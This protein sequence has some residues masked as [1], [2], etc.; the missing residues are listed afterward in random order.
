MNELLIMGLCYVLDHLG[1]EYKLEGK[2][3]RDWSPLSCLFLAAQEIDDRLL[4]IGSAVFDFIPKYSD[5]RDGLIK[6]TT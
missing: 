1:A 2:V 4:S 5:Y 3:K 6:R